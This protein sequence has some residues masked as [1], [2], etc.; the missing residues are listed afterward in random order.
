L[1][2]ECRNKEREALAAV[3]ESLRDEPGQ[4]V[5][6]LSENTGVEETLILKFIREGKVASDAVIGTVPCGRCGKPAES[7]AMRLCPKCLSQL[8]RASASLSAQAQ[9]KT[10][11]AAAGDSGAAESPKSASLESDQEGDKVHEVIETKRK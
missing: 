2:A 6:E 8:Q 10:S 7:L 4:T 3:T 11:A 5:E 9:S 1:C